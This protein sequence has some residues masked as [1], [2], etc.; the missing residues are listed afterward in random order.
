MQKNLKKKLRNKLKILRIITSLDPKFGGP[1]TGI[2]ESS[3]DLISKGHSVTILTLDKNSKYKAGTNRIK[4]I[5]FNNYIGRNYKLS[6]SF[7]YWLFKK[8]K[9]YDHVIIH[10]IWQF[11]TFAARLLLRGK[12][13]VFVHGQLDPYFRFN[14]AKKIKKQLYWF[15]F[16]KR[17]LLNSKS[18]LLTSS[19]EKK[20]LNNTFVN[21]NGI[22]KK[23]INYGINK[24]I[25]NKNEVKRLF[26]KKCQILDIKIFI[27]F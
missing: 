9:T 16:E 8:H 10:G 7:F 26:Y 13:Y 23:V 17:N 2:I 22:T 15:L 12:Y 4:I 3:K 19:G 6:F 5:N 27:Y 25:I 1:A 11:P 21:C 14:W 18:I 20:N 24:P